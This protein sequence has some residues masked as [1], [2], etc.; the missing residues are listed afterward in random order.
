MGGD[1]ST[2]NPALESPRVRRE[3]F[4]FTG[5]DDTVQ[6]MTP[7]EE[8]ARLNRVIHQ[9]E[10]VYKTT[11]DSEQ[12]VRVEK[13]LRELRNYR[14]KILAVNVI[15]MSAVQETAE[16]PDHM[17]EFPFL[18]GLIAREASLPRQQRL[19]LLWARDASPTQTQQEVFH[20]MLYAKWFR[21]EFLP[22]LTEKRLKLDFKFSLDRDAFY[23][24]FQDLERKLD[25]FREE[26][27]RLTE[28]VVSR[29]MEL[30]LRKRITKLKRETEADAGKLFQALLAFAR[31]LQEDAHG[32][33]VKCLNGREHIAFDSIEGRRALQGWVVRDALEELSRLASEVRTYLNVPDIET[34]ES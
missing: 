1:P 28:G 14:E 22:F 15:D 20:L 27:A 17:A 29:E 6:G 13:Q 11:S 5:R 12:R 24:R 25:H 3:G 7:E 26:N 34:Q 30:E 4:S 32:E 8:L 31:E 18:D 2:V 21:D 33:G 10:S 9:F 16:K 23:A 19:G